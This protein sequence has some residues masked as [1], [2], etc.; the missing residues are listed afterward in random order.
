[1]KFL[2][3]VV[4]VYTSW[5]NKPLVAPVLLMEVLSCMRAWFKTFSI[6]Y[7]ASL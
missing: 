5:W 7:L 4:S 6:N 1:M 3:S 2:C